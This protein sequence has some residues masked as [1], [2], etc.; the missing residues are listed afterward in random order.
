[1]SSPRRIVT[2]YPSTKFTKS[3]RRLPARIQVLAKKK[4]KLFGNDAFHS[5]LKTH[6]LSGKLK[7]NWA[8]SVDRR[9]RVMFRFVNKDKVVYLD[10]GTHEVYR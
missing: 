7:E 9:Y 5:T 2:I 6:K 8:Y 1:M 10:V 3:Y 4:D